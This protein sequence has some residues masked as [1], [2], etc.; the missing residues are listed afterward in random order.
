MPPG[1][2]RR[3]SARGLRVH[4][5]AE[6]MQESRR[7]LDVREEER[8]GAFA[9]RSSRMARSS[10]C[11]DPESSRMLWDRIACLSQCSGMCPLALGCLEYGD[12]PGPA[13]AGACDGLL[14]FLKVPERGKLRA[15]VE[16]DGHTPE[17]DPRYKT[18]IG[19]QPDNA[20]S[21]LRK[22]GAGSICYAISHDP[23]LYGRTDLRP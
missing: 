17:I 23:E 11:R 21:A 19:S 3:C 20:Y 13:G 12:C 8:D 1:S 15:T 22:S 16:R 9:G 2:L 6:R 14:R 10:A 5:G 18:P 7:S 4:L